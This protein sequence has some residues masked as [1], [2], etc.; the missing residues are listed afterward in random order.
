[1]IFSSIKSLIIQFIFISA[2]FSCSEQWGTPQP[3]WSG[4]CLNHST[5]TSLCKYLRVATFTGHL[6]D[7]I[8]LI[9]WQHLTRLTPIS[10]PCSG[11]LTMCG[12]LT[13]TSKRRLLLINKEMMTE[14]WGRSTASKPTLVNFL[15]YQDCLKMKKSQRGWGCCRGSCRV[16]S[17]Y[18]TKREKK[19]TT[20]TEDKGNIFSNLTE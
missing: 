14:N 8:Y 4:F 9:L 18:H 13:S 5:E 10:L 19:M 3:T 17:Q 2:F 7:L 6:P 16:Q 11:L 1:M 20:E 15:N 12:L